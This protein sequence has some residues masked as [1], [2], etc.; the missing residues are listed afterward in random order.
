MTVKP[1][2]AGRR[3]KTTVRYSAPALEKGLDIL[4]FLAGQSVAR[5]QTEIAAALGRTQSEIYRMLA[6]LEARGY[7]LRE[8]G[9]NCYRLSLRLFELAHRQ[10]AVALLREAALGPMDEA[11]EATGQS[12]HLSVPYAGGVMVLLERRPA[13]RICLAVGEGAALPMSQSASGCV[14]LSRLPETK[15]RERLERDEIYRGLSA[16]RQRAVRQRIAC[17]RRDGHLVAPSFVTP[18]AV[19]IAFPVGVAGTDTAAVLDMPFIAPPGQAQSLTARY[20]EAVRTCAETINR[21]L[22]VSSPSPT[23]S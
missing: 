16:A 6:C 12:V 20:V 18:G 23:D 21:N 11:A 9:S 1:R 2:S 17:A 22:G 14:L 19:D 7:L 8:P 13:R 4:E 15:A 5:S 3:R 10:D